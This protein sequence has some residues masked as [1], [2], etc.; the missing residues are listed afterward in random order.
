MQVEFNALMKNEM[1][2][3]VPQSASRNLVGCR[4]VFRLKRNVDDFVE[5]HKARL[6]AKGFHQQA[7][8]DFGETFS[9]IMK[10]TTIRTTLSL[11]YST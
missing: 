6:V 5:H 8:V 10:P 4:W 9:P 11:A 1:W 2:T 3:L 7:G